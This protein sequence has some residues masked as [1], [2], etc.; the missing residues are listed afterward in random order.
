MRQNRSDAKRLSAKD[1]ITMGIFTAILAVI[2]FVV[3]L[4]SFFPVFIPLLTILIPLV[5]GI[6]FILF[7]TKVKKFGMVTVIGAL[8]GIINGFLGMGYYVMLT[9]VLFGFLADLVLKS[10]NYTSKVRN[11][12]GYGVYCMWLIGN[13]IPIVIA[14]DS[15]CQNLIDKGMGQEYANALSMYI[16]DWSLPVLLAASFVFGILGGLIGIALNRRHFE[17]AGMTG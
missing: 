13:Y 8:A 17:R 9:G 12:L 15:Y 3:A 4:L 14:R 7:L 16:P 2:T 6:P 5:E 11:V 10:G 1:L